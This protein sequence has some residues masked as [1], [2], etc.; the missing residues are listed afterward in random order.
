MHEI[1]PTNWLK[2]PEGP[3]KN[4][5]IAIYAS[6]V[7]LSLYSVVAIFLK[8]EAI[9]SYR[10]WE[11]SYATYSNTSRRLELID[12]LETLSSVDGY[13]WYFSLPF[14]VAV[15]VW[16]YNAHIAVQPLVLQK[17][18]WGIGWSIGGWFTPIGF[19]FIP[20][21][22][23]RETES[24]V[25]PNKEKLYQGPAWF[26]CSWGAVILRRIAE[27]MFVDIEDFSSV[28]LTYILGEILTIAAV[29]LAALYFGEISSSVN[30]RKPEIDTA[31]AVT[32]INNAA[33]PPPR[34]EN[35]VASATEQIRALGQL[36]SEGLIS[37]DE[38]QSKKSE[39]L[40]RF[41]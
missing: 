32:K 36:L 27:Q 23:N 31:K 30:L 16:T 21:L 5:L 15:I 39:L 34:V 24:I 3:L 19:L 14:L 33:M 11:D 7:A 6:G 10:A 9:S 8:I 22:V 29:V 40:K 25:R 20:L 18:K 12:E 37:D 4:Y 17:R 1:V 41:R 35:D 26:I 13:L 28:M 38:F 2:N